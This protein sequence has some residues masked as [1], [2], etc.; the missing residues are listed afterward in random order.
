MDVMILCNMTH[1][2]QLLL[3]VA[4]G[5]GERE[6]AFGREAALVVVGSRVGDAVAPAQGNQMAKFD[7]VPSLDSARVEGGERNPRKGRD[8][9]LLHSVAEP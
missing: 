6:E 2:H 8:Q 4:L 1:F 7:P 3:N 5:V 9:I